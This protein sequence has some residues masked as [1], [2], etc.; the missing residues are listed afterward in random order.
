MDGNGRISFCLLGATR[1]VVNLYHYDVMDKALAWDRLHDLMPDDRT[2]PMEWN[3]GNGRHHAQV[4][5]LLDRAIEASIAD[6]R[7]REIA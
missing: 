6:E 7:L 5:A 3:D 2:S 4:V 1:F